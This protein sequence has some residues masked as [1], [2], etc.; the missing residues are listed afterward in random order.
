MDDK[1]FKNGMHIKCTHKKI[2][3]VNG[4]ISYQG[5]VTSRGFF[6]KSGTNWFIIIKL[7]W[8]LILFHH[9]TFFIRIITWRVRAC[10]WPWLGWWLQLHIETLR[11]QNSAQCLFPR[12]VGPS[13]SPGCTP[14]SFAVRPSVYGDH[15][16]LQQGPPLLKEKH[17]Y[18]GHYHIFGQKDIYRGHVTRNRDIHQAV[19][20]FNVNLQS[21]ERTPLSQDDWVSEWSTSRSGSANL[22]WCDPPGQT[23]PYVQSHMKNK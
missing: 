10:G 13:G 8:L 6:A 11:P 23:A 4:K 3:N 7:F 2:L 9:I 16:T 20:A 15:I 18:M 12:D 21:F 22:G 19:E 14:K 5:S 1:Y 17:L